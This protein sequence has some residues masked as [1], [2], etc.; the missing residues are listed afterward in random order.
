MFVLTTMVYPAAL[1]A[2]CL[3]GGLLADRLAGRWLPGSLL[4]VIG[5]AALI[6]LSQ[7]STYSS[8]VAPATPYLMLA[9]A[10]AGLALERSRLLELARRLRARPWPLLVAVLAYAIALAPVLAAGRPT[11][12]SY[13]ALADSAVH[14][15][16]ADYLVR[17]GQSFA[18]LDLRNSYGRVISAYYNA[19]YPSGAD[20]LLGGSS[21]LLHLPVIWC[22]QPFNAFVLAAG[23]GPAWHIARRTRLPSPVAAAAALTCVL[24]ALDYAYELLGSI[25]ELTA[26]AMILALGAL[27]VGHRSWLWGP[28]RRAGIFGLVVGAGASAL[29]AAFGA[30]ALAAVIALAGAFAVTVR[31]ARAHSAQLLASSATGILVLLVAAWPTWRQLSGSLRV[32]RQIASTSNSGNL[33]TPLHTEQVL[34]VWLRGSY[35]LS[36]H[37][38]SLAATHVLVAAVL[39][40][41][42]L[43]VLQLLRVRAFALAGWVALMLLVWLIVSR[44]VTTW[45]EAK[46]LVLTSPVVILLAWAGVGLTGAL[47]SRLAAGATAGVLALAIAGGVLAS[48]WLQYHTSNLAPSGR[49]E[50]LASLDSRLAGRGPAL[51]TDFDEWSLYVL[52]GLDVGG[53]DFIYPPPALAGIAAGNGYPVDLDAARPAALAAYRLIVTRRDPMSSRPPAAY[54]LTWRGRYYEAWERLP[55]SMAAISHTPLSGSSAHQCAELAAVARTARAVRGLWLTAAS[56]PQI[57]PVPLLHASHPRRWGH[58]R[59]G[60]VMSSA[61]TLETHVLV[62]RAGKWNIWVRGQIMPSLAVRLDGHPIEHLSGQLG[63]NSL[64]VN[65]VPPRAVRLTGGEHRLELTLSRSTFAPGD[66]GA[67]LL[68]A[69]FLTPARAGEERPLVAVPADRWR[70]LC[71]GRYQWLELSRRRPA[72]DVALPQAAG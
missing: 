65:L 68:A 29:G 17:H 16:G 59:S 34:G 28:A 10:L 55:S 3:G 9:A 57:I 44:S 67:A 49:Y 2:L 69:V 24:A 54:R 19:S 62:P 71:G 61:G 21:L 70:R 32:A 1:A 42:L 36:P 23:T 13:L 12:S 50:E 8:F 15:A 33:R 38:A 20:T 66:D 35:K 27:V 39:A 47:P 22:F 14:M 25:K 4:L 41:A 63:G 51:F 48:D 45:A 40:C 11:F 7:L 26:L 30:W 56:A 46:T 5:M 60:L 18:H 52:R 58:A 72:P 31:S 53:P 64:V 43:G 37:G 6:A